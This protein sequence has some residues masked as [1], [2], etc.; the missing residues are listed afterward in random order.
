MEKTYIVKGTTKCEV[1]LGLSFY[2]PGTDFCEE[3]PERMRNFYVQ[4]L[5]NPVVEEKKKE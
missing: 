3:I 2:K 4:L 5:D 1:Q